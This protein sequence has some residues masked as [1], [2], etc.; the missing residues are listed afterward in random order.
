[1]PSFLDTIRTSQAQEYNAQQL[2]TLISIVKQH[3]RNFLP[4]IFD[5]VGR[6]WRSN[7]DLHITLI[8]L[9]ETI[10]LALEADCAAYVPRM[11]GLMLDVLQTDTTERRLPTQKF[12]QAL[13]AFGPNIQQYMFLVVPELTKVFENRDLPIH[14]RTLALQTMCHL[15][16]N[17]YCA[18]QASR[19]IQPLVRVLAEQPRPE[20]TEPA[21]DTL[22]ALIL[23]MRS[24]Y[25]PFILTVNRVRLPVNWEK[26]E[27]STKAFARP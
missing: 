3:I 22:C 23:Q 17:V 1:M 2:G 16:R 7:V 11:L 5:L 12:L 27:A 26:C 14:I 19:I 10:A 25:A 4:G 18:D 9:V 13:R 24:N 21:M 20:L 15:C 6:L 8:G